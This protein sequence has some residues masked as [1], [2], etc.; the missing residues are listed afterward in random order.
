MPP[1]PAP[2]P[3]PA[4]RAGYGYVR[5]AEGVRARLDRRHTSARALLGSGAHTPLRFTPQQHSNSS[6]ATAPYARSLEEVG[7]TAAPLPAAAAAEE[8]A[9][10]AEEEPD[11]EEEEDDE[12]KALR[13]VIHSHAQ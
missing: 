3:A 2:A 1:A 11:A 10:E 9:E 5:W 13:S 8:E 6:S 7:S 4:L 12:E